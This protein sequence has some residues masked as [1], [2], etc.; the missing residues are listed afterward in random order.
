MEKQ[1]VEKKN[2]PRGRCVLVCC[3]EECTEM[4]H[5]VS[6]YS[7]TKQTS[8]AVKYTFQNEQIKNGSN[9]LSWFRQLYILTLSCDANVPTHRDVHTRHSLSSTP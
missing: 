4:W 1:T 8:S 7:F 3:G 5:D 6:S 9:Q 2:G